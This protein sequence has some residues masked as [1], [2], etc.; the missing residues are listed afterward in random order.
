[1]SDDDG[2]GTASYHP[3]NPLFPLP[4]SSH[5]YA[6]SPLL[7]E[8]PSF[9][10]HFRTPKSTDHT[11]NTAVNKCNKCSQIV[12]LIMLMRFGPLCLASAVLASPAA[13]AAPTARIIA[14]PALK[15]SLQALMDELA[16]AT[17]FALQLGYV[18]GDGDE[19]GLAA[20]T[21]PGGGTAEL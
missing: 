18:D 11:Q 13:S 7:N 14:D 2:A 9:R 12:V 17:G 16:A 20:G 5:R 15:A 19:Y 3:S 8:K 10:E 6:A 1:M 21:K 4:L